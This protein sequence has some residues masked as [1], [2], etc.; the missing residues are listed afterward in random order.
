M[1]EL[2]GIGPLDP[3]CIIICEDDC[4]VCH[5]QAAKMRDKVI[6]DMA[7]DV[8]KTGSRPQLSSSKKV[9]FTCDDVAS[10]ELA[11]FLNKVYSGARISAGAGE[12]KI[13]KTVTGTLADILKQ[14]GL[15]ASA[16]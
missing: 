4:G 2:C 5:V 12:K 6:L 10:Q 8:F 11:T 15:E 7:S 9:Q 14:T 3:P 13:S 16:Y 1:C